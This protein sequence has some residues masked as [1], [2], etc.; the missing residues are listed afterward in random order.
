[1]YFK[2]I[3]NMTS[4]FVVISFLFKVIADYENP[5][6]LQE[7]EM[8]SRL[9]LFV[10]FCPW[11]ISMMNEKPAQECRKSTTMM[12][13]TKLGQAILGQAAAILS[14]VIEREYRDLDLSPIINQL[15]GNCRSSLFKMNKK[16][17]IFDYFRFKSDSFLCERF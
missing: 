3:M 11:K 13:G 8:F 4:Q 1:M 15:R 12:S 16:W 9:F 5:K 14:M 7:F 6:L 10:L 17:T 2:L